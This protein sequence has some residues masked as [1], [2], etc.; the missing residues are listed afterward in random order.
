MISLSEFIFLDFQVARHPA[1]VALKNASTEL[2][3]HYSIIVYCKSTFEQPRFR[4][5]IVRHLFLLKASIYAPIPDI[6][7][8]MQNYIY[9]TL[10][11]KLYRV[12]QFT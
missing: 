12:L 4:H 3:S 7:S 8:K 1:I 10:D 11:K 5:L 9:Y 2:D 6:L